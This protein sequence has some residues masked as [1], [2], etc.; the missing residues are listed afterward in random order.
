MSVTVDDARLWIK[1]QVNCPE[2]MIATNIAATNTVYLGSP[3]ELDCNSWHMGVQLENLGTVEAARKYILLRDDGV[4]Q[5]DAKI[6]I[7]NF[8]DQKYVG[9]F[10]NKRTSSAQEEAVCADTGL[11]SVLLNNAT[12]HKLLYTEAIGTSQSYLNRQF[13]PMLYSHDVPISMKPGETDGF[14]FV[15]ILTAAAYNNRLQSN[16]APNYEALVHQQVESLF[17][18]VEQQSEGRPVYFIS[19]AWGCGV[20]KNSPYTIFGCMRKHILNGSNGQLHLI[21][22]VP[23]GSNMMVA[24]SQFNNELHQM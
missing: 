20:F 4:L 13:V 14:K 11:Y 12:G 18:F 16:K 9:G 15:D 17:N 24:Q 7:H 6:V 3:L 10:F 1:K 21:I 23:G 19:G 8:A 2:W 5:K 22:A